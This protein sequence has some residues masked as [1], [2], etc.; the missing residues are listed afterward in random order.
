MNIEFAGS[1]YFPLYKEGLEIYW[2]HHTVNF[3]LH[4]VHFVMYCKG[5][6]LTEKPVGYYPPARG[7][8]WVK[9]F[10]SRVHTEQQRQRWHLRIGMGPITC[11]DASVNADD[12]A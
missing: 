7:S 12:V 8:P 10:L 3:H 5:I 11:A 4:I 6:Y 9:S 2:T 1:W